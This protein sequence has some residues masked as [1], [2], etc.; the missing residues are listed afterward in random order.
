MPREVK[1]TGSVD[2]EGKLDP[3]KMIW[4]LQQ[5][6]L[7]AGGAIEIIIRRPKRSIR[8]NRYYW[9]VINYIVEYRRDAGQQCSAA[10][11]H[12]FFK[13][14]HL[15]NI[16]ETGP[17]GKDILLPASTAILN[18]TDFHNY[19]EAIKNSEYI[20]RDLQLYIPTPEELAG[21]PMRGYKIHEIA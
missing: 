13:I 19:L 2:K 5:L 12:A 16:W 10:G 7:F 4:L 11:M 9:A 20:R 6:V 8:A 18:S 14:Q 1:I 3:L 17:D 21:K 15:Q